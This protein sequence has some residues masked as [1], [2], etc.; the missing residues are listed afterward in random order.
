M[1]ETDSTPKVI[2]NEYTCEIWASKRGQSNYDY[3][4][5]PEMDS[6]E[7]ITSPNGKEALAIVKQRV[8]LAFKANNGEIKYIIRN[9]SCLDHNVNSERDI[10]DDDDKNP[11]DMVI[12][13]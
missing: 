12:H 9:F 8:R 4:G 1:N 10:L 6:M 3:W 5:T 13:E 11:Q 2:L 7:V